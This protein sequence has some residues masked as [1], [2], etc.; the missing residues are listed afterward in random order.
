MVRQWGCVYT[1]LM[2]SVCLLLK[3]AGFGAMEAEPLFSQNTADLFVRQA[4]VIQ[5]QHA[6][7]SQRIEQAMVFLDAALAIDEMSAGVPEQ[8]LRMGPLSGYADKDYSRSI[9]WAL[10][11]QVDGRADLI[12]LNGAVQYLLEQQN[13]RLDREVLLEQ[14]LKKYPSQNK[15]FTSDLA[16][17]LGLLAVEKADLETAM[18]RLSYAYDLNP[19]NQLAFAKLQEL[20]PS[21]GLSV[22]PG[23]YGVGL[24]RA[25]DINPYDLPRAVEYADALKSLQSYEAAMSAY[26]YAAKLYE[27]LL[28][29]EPLD[30][31]IFLP[32][33]M[34]AYQAPRQETACLEVI[35]QY[36]H[37]RD[38]DLTTE[39]VAGKT[40]MKLGRLDKANTILTQASQKA[41]NLL[42]ENRLSRPMH[43]EQLAWFYCFVLDDS[44]KALAWANRAFKE[45]PARQGVKDIFAYTL[46]QSGQMELAKDYAADN[47][48]TNQVASLTMALVSLADK[49]DTEAIAR[50]KSTIDLAHESFVAAKAMQL[51]ASRGSEYIAPAYMAAAE[52][53]LNAAYEQRVVPQFLPPQKR[54]SAKLMFSGSEFSYGNQLLPKLTIKNNSAMPLVIA[55]GA[56]LQGR[57]RVDAKLTGDLNVEMPNIL[58]TS[59]RPS[60][61]IM[62]GEHVSVPLTVETGK[63]RRILLTYPQAN[64]EVAFTVYLDPVTDEAGKVKNA[65]QG[66][67]PVTA[68]IQRPGINITRD[69][70]MQRLDSLAKGRPGQQFRAVRLFSGLLAEQ[71]AFE[72]SG[73]AFR[74]VQVDQTLLIDS[75]RRALNDEN[76]KVQIEAM[77]A[78]L[79][80][81]IPLDAGVV[82]DISRNL[83]HDK[84]PVRL[85][86]MYLLAQAQPDSFQKVLD[87]TAEYDLHWLNRRMAIGLGAKEP[88][89][90]L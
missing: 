25:L 45:A 80:L 78:L 8:I 26:Q 2:V 9:D 67:E 33:L 63:L 23:A 83:H 27:F 60:R 21:Q 66:L 59:F 38:F 77:D 35:E 73:A 39:A 29:D 30:D 4:M 37:R 13:S 86:A 19:Y 36:R 72:I 55:P 40:W 5:Q 31:A 43:P 44:D 69:F 20:L 12:L 11:R 14:L 51:L 61:P 75:V 68:Q 50:L 46:A 22:T 7:D 85:M 6:T 64:I 89:Q 1:F 74:Y 16:T 87:W 49:N 47:H 90:A 52:Q 71:K 76:W 82:A 48:E 84:W 56:V 70:L 81:S 15:A 42:Q 41:E 17:Q 53:D 3:G 34:C 62:P 18:N 28:P 32:W 54:F 79:T 65:L 10:Q 57:L 24:R 58:S 88:Q